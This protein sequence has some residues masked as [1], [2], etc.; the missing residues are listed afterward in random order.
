MAPQENDPL[1]AHLPSPVAVPPSLFQPGA[2]QIGA[3]AQLSSSP[4]CSQLS[5]IQPHY[6]PSK[7]KRPQCIAH[8]GYKS[9]YP[10]NTMSAFRAAVNAGAHAI[11]TD[12]QITKDDVVVLSHDA[13]LKRCFGQDIKIA[14]KDWEELE[15]VRTIEKPHER[16]P[17][18]ADLLHYLAEEGNEH[19][20]V[21]LDIKLNND[22]ERIMRLIASTL[23]AN[24]P[25]DSAPWDQRIV[26]GLWAVK[27]LPPAQQYLSGFPMMHIA[28][29]TTYARQFLQVENVGFNM[30]F[31]ALLMP[32]GNQFLHDAQK[33]HK[34]K[35][36]S[37]TI[38]GED[39]MKWCIRRGL[40][41][42]V[43]DEVEK[44]LEVADRFDEGEEKESWLPVDLKVLW[45][46]MKAYIWVRVLL[47]F[48][49]RK[50]G[51][52]LT[53]SGG[54]VTGEERKR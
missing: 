25:Q 32:G 15:D 36:L 44:Y 41:G 30:M 31:Y 50:M 6:S 37:W 29:S 43:T 49:K 47:V 16:L 53:I 45:T 21:F 17:R 12:L 46:A 11:E 34:R 7:R 22:A 33:V 18:L 27:Y 51:L 38:N 20:W 8:R 35:V 10:E 5:F 1:L 28:F 24:P 9:K 4:G 40:D 54:R 14:D 39:N 19:I 42:V 48:Y 23:Q 3:S 26:L 13:N 2:Q 52:G